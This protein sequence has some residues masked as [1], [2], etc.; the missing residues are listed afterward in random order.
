VREERVDGER[1]RER[2]RQGGER[3]RGRGDHRE[4]KRDKKVDTKANLFFFVCLFLL[5]VRKRICPIYQIPKKRFVNLS[6]Q[7]GR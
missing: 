5:Q 6:N 4:R 1:E 2:D 3:K 7:F